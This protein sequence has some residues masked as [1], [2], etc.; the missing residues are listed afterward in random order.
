M[1]KANVKPSPPREVT[2]RRRLVAQ[3]SSQPAPAPEPAPPL[4]NTDVTLDVSAASELVTR[5]IASVLRQRQIPLAHADEERGRVS[6]GPVPLNDAQMRE[7]VPAE[8]FRGTK[9]VTGRYYLSCKIDR[10]AD[11]RSRVIISALIVLEYP[12]VSSPIGG[13]I[14]SLAD[15]FDALTSARPYRTAMPQAKATM[16]LQEGR[17]KQWDRQIVDALLESIAAQAEQPIA[18]PAPRPVPQLTQAPQVK[19]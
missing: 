13:R 18:A 5:A 1:A 4:P 9:Q 2:P 7:A 16:I 15:V 12:E 11:Q 14:V 6:I 8:F 17:G 10:V 3:A 19:F